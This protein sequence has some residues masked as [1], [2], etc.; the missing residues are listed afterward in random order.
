M[1]GVRAVLQ[2]GKETF[3]IKALTKA[4]RALGASTIFTQ[5]EVAKGME[6]MSRAS[7]GTV[8]IIEQLPHAL[9]LAIAGGVGFTEG[10]NIMITTMKQFSTD[11]TLDAEK[12]ADVMAHVTSRFKTNLSELGIALRFV[13]GEASTMGVSFKETALAIGLLSDRGIS[14]SRAGTTLRRVMFSLNKTSARSVAILEDVGLTMNDISTIQT[15]SLFKSMNKLR[16]AGM[17]MNQVLDFFQ[18]RGTAGGAAFMEM[19]DAMAFARA[20]AQDLKGTAAEMAKVMMDNVNKQLKILWSAIIHLAGTIFGEGLESLTALIAAFTS[21]VSWIDRAIQGYGLLFDAI[22]KK[23]QAKWIEKLGEEEGKKVND[24]M[25]QMIADNPLAGHGLVKIG[26]D[27]MAETKNQADLLRAAQDAAVSPPE[28]QAE[29]KTLI[30]DI[31]ESGLM[32]KMIDTEERIEASEQIYDKDAS[33]QSKKM[34]DFMRRIVEMQ[35][36]TGKDINKFLKDAGLTPKVTQVSDDPNEPGDAAGAKRKADTKRRK[37]ASRLKKV[38]KDRNR[39][40]DQEHNLLLMNNKLELER[41]K[42]SLQGMDQEEQNELVMRKSQELARKA[43]AD[44]ARILKAQ[45]ANQMAHTIDMVKLQQ[46]VDADQ[47]KSQ[48]AILRSKIAQ[49]EKE[50][51]LYNVKQSNLVIDEQQAKAIRETNKELDKQNAKWEH[52]ATLKEGEQDMTEMGMRMKGMSEE[53]ITQARFDFDQ[54][55]VLDEIIHKQNTLKT[56]QANP[57]TEHLDLYNKEVLALQQEIE[58]LQQ[59]SE[60]LSAEEALFQMQDQLTMA[61]DF[62]DAWTG[63]FQDILGQIAQGELDLITTLDNLANKLANDVFKPLFDD[64]NAA[65][66]ET[67]MKMGKGMGQAVMAGLAIAVMA[68]SSFLKKQKAETES[69]ADEAAED[70]VDSE[71]VRGVV[72]GEQNVAIAKINDT[73]AAAFRPTEGHLSDIKDLIAGAMGLPTFSEDAGLTESAQ[74]Q[75]GFAM[76]SI[77]GARR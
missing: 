67:F 22:K 9:N 36:T 1:T 58:Q 69:L 68:I 42:L 2:L 60:I 48:E 61:A 12:V 65:L 5:T 7:L 35:R 3:Q 66:K 41:Y 74:T 77:A 32:E 45:L 51:E 70:L 8:E 59:R 34:N 56:M 57:P 44:K 43:F 31:T 13:G 25:D 18:I 33:E 10:V 21:L 54:G 20:A 39:I 40:L 27:A 37:E 46:E 55:A 23:G 50:L 75:G 11:T 16:K 4:A 62:A 17:N 47:S 64:I 52:Q 24:F 38:L 6:L 28:K 19:A 14:A 49:L 72:A 63:G 76:E 15:K 30:K 29:Y 73:I 26:R 53:S 71:K